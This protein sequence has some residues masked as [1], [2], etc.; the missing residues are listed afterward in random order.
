MKKLITTTFLLLSVIMLY[1]QMQI[2]GK[3][4][5]DEGLALIGA[6]V[7][8][9]GTVNGTVTD[10][11]GNFTL[12]VSEATRTIRV[13]Y[14]GYTIQDIT[15]TG[16][17]R[18]DI[19][20]LTSSE[21]LDEV[22]VIGYGTSSKR[23]LTDN[24][25]KLSSADIEKVP[26]SNFQSTMS[27]KAAGVRVTQINGKVDAGII[28]RVRGASSISAGNDPL[29]VLD[30]VPLINQ[31]ESSNGAPMNPL[32]SLSTTEIESID[33]L[34]DASSAAIYGARG[35]NGVVLITT[36]RGKPGKAKVS[37]NLSKGS[38]K[39]T[40]LVEWLNADQY[41]ELFT[42]AAANGLEFGGW[43]GEGF[44]EGRFD[45]YS[46]NTDWA[47]GEV[48]TDWNDIAFRTGS[49]SNAN[50]SVSG[51]DEI[52]TYYFGG[53][54][55]DTKGIILGNDL[56]RISV[57][58]NIRNNFSE[59]FTAG[60]NIGYSKTTIERVAN[61]N[62][63]VTPLQAIAQ[64]PISPARLDDGMPFAGTVYPNFLLEHDF[65][66][67]TTR[68]R[69]LTGKAYAEYKILPFLKVNSDFGYDM[70]YITE[71]QFRGSNT[72]FQST[73]GEAY[74]SNTTQEGYVFTNYLTFNKDL[75]SVHNLD[76]VVG[77]EF[78]DTK[79]AWTTVTGTEFPSDDFQT[80][81]S[82]AE[83]TAG[84]GF[85]TAYTFASIFARGTYVYDGKYFIKGSIRRD[86]SSR[87]GSNNRYGVF[88]AGSIGWI[89]SEEG[90]MKNSK[91]L[92]FLKLR[93]S[94][95]ELGNSEIGDFPSRFLFGGV[96]YNQ[97]PG[98]AP[99]QPGNNDL[100]WETSRQLD[101]GVEFGFFNNR[102][103]AEFDFYTKNT[104]G[105]LFSVPLPGSSGAGSIN[106]NI[107]NLEN[108]GVE[109]LLNTDNI[110][111][112]EL[113]WTTSFNLS[114]NTN[115]IKT[116]PND[117]AD[118][119]FGRNINRTGESVSSFFMPEYAGVDPDNGDA[120]YYINGEDGDPGATTNDIGEAERVVAGNP[121]PDWTAGITNNVSYKG[122]TLSFTFMGEWGA[123]IYN[124][125]GR[126]QSS[127]ADWFDNQTVDQMNRWQNPGDV[128]QVPQA[129][130]GWG[131]GTGH[132][133]RW[134]NN[135][136]FIRLRNVSLSY[137]LPASILETVGFS[138]IQVYMSGI[139]LLTFT[140]YPGYD[141]ESRADFGGFSTGQTFYSAPAAK[142]ISFGINLNF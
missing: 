83:I 98:I 30:G 100:T 1:G 134:L 29:Y 39:A 52:T 68:M 118:I 84:S 140:D 13:S 69:R 95:G 15:L 119:I 130:L 91:T 82:A 88:P 81:N 3:I 36:K 18:Y 63:F 109:L 79:R 21:T 22:I 38:S 56:D 113:E 93:A 44:V 110:T 47:N 16:A 99:T 78:N 46:N 57:R 70:N 131:N 33:I 103:S 111:G 133:T 28:I 14:T 41:I 27:G 139:N 6:T 97:R 19:V 11:D 117:D 112:K 64:A 126:F 87:F 89:V 90:F 105:L 4:V 54:Y 26:I 60:L 136:D 25:A 132:S 40:N 127:N 73:N 49:Q 74:S 129:R 45:R 115:E 24:I 120:L 58:T 35:A 85:S 77:V 59:K 2:T 102:I 141:P 31:N 61:D 62:G 9:V 12:Q 7:L 72:P 128:T 101:L 48:D 43:P 92:S 135:A 125:G 108:K 122:V 124:G 5:D 107:G 32:L 142:T 121:F 50:F 137:D 67:Y 51:G 106:R 65:A 104:D 8:E 94:Y 42:E 86:G 116:L 17:S 53:S 71:D 114:R 138:G 76:M 66:N 10:F 75:G 37:L 123:D 34:K 20:L 96:S 23:N 80:I 55:N